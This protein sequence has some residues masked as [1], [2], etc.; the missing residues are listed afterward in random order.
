[1]VQTMALDHFDGAANACYDY[2]ARQGYKQLASAL[3]GRGPNNQTVLGAGMCRKLASDG[4]QNPSWSYEF[5]LPSTFDEKPISECRP[6]WNAGF[7]NGG[8]RIRIGSRWIARVM[9]VMAWSWFGLGN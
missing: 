8:D 7:A 1:M 9:M 2:F 3:S 5:G 4:K 6:V